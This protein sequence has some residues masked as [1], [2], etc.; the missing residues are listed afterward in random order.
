LQFSYVREID[1]AADWAEPII[2]TL[3]GSSRGVP[4]T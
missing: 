2:P 1:G 4:M 3:S